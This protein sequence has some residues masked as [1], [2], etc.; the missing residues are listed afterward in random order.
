VVTP[1]LTI[2]MPVYNGGRFIRQALDSLLAQT[3][4]DFELVIS[5]NASQDNTEGICREY[6]GRDARIRYLR[7]ERNLG[8]FPN[9]DFVMRQARGSYFML[10]GDDDLYAPTYVR[11]LVDVL[12]ADDSVGLAYS[13][14]GYVTSDGA[15]V[16][17]GT[18]VFMR[19]SWSP[20]RNLA[21]HMWKR[22]VLPMIMG[23][24]RTEVVRAA[25]PFV[26]F[27][28]MLGGIDLVFMARAL[29]TTRVESIP[30]VLF[31]YRL[32]DRSSSIPADWPS[33]AVRRRWSVWKLNARVTREMA[34]AVN[35][36]DL[37]AGT[38]AALTAFSVLSLAAHLVAVPVIETARSM[39]RRPANAN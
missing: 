19:A 26:S 17:G 9:V 25:L 21:M 34:R 30:D 20:A 33:G 10:V 5:D 1:R 18:T 39:R 4:T 7:Q 14:F 31:W 29:A 8:L 2:G 11:K 36:S 27:G 16:P 37:G 3:F 28:S 15:R 32:K 6:A 24:F 13:D 38:K 22:P 23:L 12:A 35:G